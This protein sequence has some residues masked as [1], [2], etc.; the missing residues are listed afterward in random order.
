MNAL[1][2]HTN[3][4][5]ARTRPEASHRFHA[6]L[7]EALDRADSPF[8]PSLG[9][10]HVLIQLGIAKDFRN[11][12]KDADA[13]VQQPEQRVI[14][15][16]LDLELMLPTLLTA[17]AQALEVVNATDTQG[18]LTNGHNGNLESGLYEGMAVEEDIPLEFMDDAMD[19]D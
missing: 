4:E 8:G 7:L 13:N 1:K 9:N 14:R 12:W 3:P 5:L 19:L 11:R 16:T 15:E 17:C 10:Q 2:F 18:Q 6:N